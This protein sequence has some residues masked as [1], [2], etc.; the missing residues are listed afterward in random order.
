VLRETLTEN[1]TTRRRDTIMGTCFHHDRGKTNTPAKEQNVSV[2]HGLLN[3]LSSWNK[4]STKM[5]F[6]NGITCPRCGSSLPLRQFF[7]RSNKPFCT[8]CGWNLDRAE[9]ALND[10]K[11]ML[12]LIALG[13]A[14]VGLFA[15][16]AAFRS[17]EPEALWFPA[18]FVVIAMVPLWNYI[19]V[20]RAITAAKSTVIPDLARTNPLA[21]PSVQL[22]LSLPRPRRVRV[23]FT[24]ILGLLTLLSAVILL[25]LLLMVP[26]PWHDSPIDS[27]N[28]PLIP[29]V[30]I[31]FVVAVMVVPAILREKR[32]WSL[33]R[34][35]DV[36][37]A[38]VLAQSRSQQGRT[39]YSRIEFEFRANSGQLVRNSQKDLSEKVFE[40]MTIPV[41]YDP[42]D[43]SKNTALCASY[44]KISDSF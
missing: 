28:S 27:K 22:L 26:F 9:A 23:N 16:F 43:P 24:G 33:F 8:R 18:I 7:A 21:L 32:N 37:L 15:M 36:A 40:E 5:F 1:I 2:K 25:C 44:L 29:V 13:V 6:V 11:T 3:S 4:R 31:T 10:T 41:F 34:D 35:G 20:R 12:K 38:R 14:G 30:F 19:S 17:H 39:T 42:L